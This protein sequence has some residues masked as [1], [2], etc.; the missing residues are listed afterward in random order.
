MLTWFSHAVCAV[1]IA[2]LWCCVGYNQSIT[3]DIVSSSGDYFTSSNASLSWTIGEPLTEAYSSNQAI[4]TQGFHQINIIVD[5]IYEEE[6]KSLQISVY[7]NP[8]IGVINLTMISQETTTVVIELFNAIGK[9]SYAEKVA[10]LNSNIRIDLNNYP[11]G[12]YFLKISKQNGE[13]IGVFKAQKV[14]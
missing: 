3:R 6:D 2:L 13:I 12:V 11:T 5:A 14:K 1:I 10:I 7:P 4:L 8:A 9:R